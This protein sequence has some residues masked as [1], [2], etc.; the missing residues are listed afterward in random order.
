MPTLKDPNFLA[1]AQFGNLPLIPQQD[2]AMSRSIAQWTQRCQHA[3]RSR[4]SLGDRCT[5]NRNT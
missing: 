2:V 3:A 4:H 1:H 5:S